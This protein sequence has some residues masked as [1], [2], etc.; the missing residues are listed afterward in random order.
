M[1]LAPLIRDLAIILGVAG[2]ISL[3]FQRIRQPV[4]LGYIIAG[5]IIGPFTP[6]FQLVTDLPS[7]QT[8]AELGVIFLMFTLG[9]EFSF[10]KLARVGGSAVL[11]ALAE[12]AFF[13]P[14]GYFVGTAL[15]WS[16]MDGL[17]LGAM[18][19]IS[20]T[21]IIIKALDELKLKKH[22]FAELI[23]AIL[24]VE[25]LIAIL[26]LVALSTV[27]TSKA[28]SA[29]ALVTAALKLVLVVG[30]WFI[31]GYFV[32][33]RFMRYVGRIGNDEMLTILSLG[34]CLTLVVFANH[35]HYSSALGA[36]IMGSIIA[37]SPVLPRIE[38]N[39]A[40][41]R[42][43][44]GAIFFVS[45]GMLI[46]PRML[47]EHKGAVLLI[48]A[49]TIVGKILSTGIGALV[50]GQ[51]LRNSVQVGF[52]LAQ[53]G[54]FSFIIAQLGLTLKVTSPFIYPIAVAVSLVTTFTTPYLIR[55]SARA[56]TAIEGRLPVVLRD[57]INRYAAQAEAR[58]AGAKARSTLLRPLLRWSINGV[59]TSVIFVVTSEWLLPMFR[60]SAAISQAVVPL[61]SWFA[62]L[63]LS[64]PFIWA[65]LTAF[66]L[67]DKTSHLQASP[68]TF[69]RIFSKILTLLWVGALSSEFFPSK[70]VLWITIVVLA[71]AFVV[72]YRRLENSYRWFERRFLASFEGQPSGSGSATSQFGHLAPWDAHLV[73]L[74]VHQNSPLVMKRISDAALRVR[75]GVNIVAIQRGREAIVTPLPSEVLLPK[76]RL[77]LLGTDEQVERVRTELESPAA[78]TEA[79]RPA[80]SY[81]LRQG[82]LSA[83]SPFIGQT[84][85]QSGFRERYHAMVVGIE[86]NGSR[87]INPDS[88]LRLEAGDLLWI[89]GERSKLSE[90]MPLLRPEIA[91]EG[92]KT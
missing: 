82:G 68:F 1:H 22:R 23:F 46:D 49:V 70:Y 92:E 72:F 24:I 48:C 44:F 15:G 89:A 83:N 78:S 76:D 56:A 50:S 17:F 57:V 25:D 58:R 30:G 37:E 4:V 8:W 7:I 62:A 36:F 20:S 39:M 79:T 91:Q 40:S 87:R 85:R 63:I 60:G 64:A 86:R 81:E 10:R 53:I 12:V 59:T 31:A 14:V 18:L 52:G 90:L 69:F 74:E 71:S 67:E 77:V 41:L 66:R 3:F 35:F 26:L 5:I 73:S 88:D 80:A 2:L 54:E 65:M 55:A 21:T 11:T 42:D 6:P 19:A 34:L 16:S 61:A 13:L 33:P 84:I 43:L 29:L 38:A 75:H 9:L 32:V 51:S 47:W 27:A 28:V 45:I